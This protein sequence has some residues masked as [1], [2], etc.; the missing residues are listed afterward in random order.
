[1]KIV[2][3]LSSNLL[4][5]SNSSDMISKIASETESLINNGHTVL[6]V[7]SGAVMYGM[8]TLGITKRPKDVPLLQSAASIGQVKLMNRYSLVFDKY[9]IKIGQIL[10]SADDFRIRKRYLNLRNTIETLIDNG[11]VPIINENDS[12]NTEELKFGD[13]DHLASL[14]SV[15]LNFDILALL[16]VVDGFYDSDPSENPEAKVIP[17]IDCIDKFH[18]NNANSKTNE[19]STGGIKAKLESAFKVA[20][21]SIEVF[22]GNGFNVSLNDVINKTAFGTYIRGDGT[23]STA[24]KSWLAFSPPADGTISIDA[25]A[26]NAMKH[27]SSLLAAGITCINGTFKQGDLIN[28]AFEGTDIARGLVNYNNSEL[29]LIKGKNSKD[30]EKILSRSTIY[31][32][33]IHKNNLFLLE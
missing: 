11:I 27:Q 13:N 21:A 30:F 14:L 7:T 29:E 32:E 16:T 6:I 8:K 20:G 4:N 5:P 23:R 26:Y 31:E 33:V 24:K 3:K 22:I 18:I 19:Y 25:G 9:K 17:L 12:I 2:I 1:M 28:I 15:M 10:L